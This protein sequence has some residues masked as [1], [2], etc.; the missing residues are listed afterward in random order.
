MPVLLDFLL[1]DE[2]TPPTMPNILKVSNPL[3]LDNLRTQ[4][5]ASEMTAKTTIRASQAGQ[6]PQ[7]RYSVIQ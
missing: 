3:F 6:E 4:L 2:A 1:L 7:A 5:E